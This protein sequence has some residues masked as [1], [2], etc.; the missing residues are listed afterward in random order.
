MNR[1]GPAPERGGTPD[2]L[3]NIRRGGLKKARATS[4]IAEMTSSDTSRAEEQFQERLYSVPA[5]EPEAP[6]SHVPAPAA[7][8]EAPAQTEPQAP[9]PVEQQPAAYTQPVQAAVQQPQSAPQQQQPAA[10]TQPAQ[11]P[12]QP[13]ATPLQ[14]HVA[15][16]QPVQY[17]PQTMQT[18]A[19]AQPEPEP[20][21]VKKAY[22]KTSFFQSK[23]SGSRMRAAY[24]ATR[25]LTGSRT[26]SEFILS[27]VEREVEALERAH[28]SGNEFAVDP[29]GVPRGRPLES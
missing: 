7:Q 6:A 14:Q 23:E 26:L 3:A 12:Q 10:Y 22:R 25:H 8:H 16:A 18:P 5:P 17:A 4:V 21:P 24:M 9:A 2:A 11:A 27:A 1:P 28:N 29:G 19:P 20:A 13:Q 15:Y